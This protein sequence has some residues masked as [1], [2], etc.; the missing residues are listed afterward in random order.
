[1]IPWHLLKPNII[2][3]MFELIKRAIE[4]LEYHIS[5]PSSQIDKDL[6]SRMINTA[7]HYPAFSVIQKQQFI[8]EKVNASNYIFEQLFIFIIVQ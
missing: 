4:S 7:Q 5:R 8:Q 1:M 3:L 6:L 2:D